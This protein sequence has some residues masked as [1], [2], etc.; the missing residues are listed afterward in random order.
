MLNCT[1]C[2]YGSPEGAK[3]CRQCGAPLFEGDFK[4]A[5]TR[6][7]GRQG[8]AVAPAA[9]A[10]LPPSIADAVAGDTARYQ[11]AVHMP[12]PSASIYTPPVGVAPAA[13]DTSSLKPKRRRILKWG[14]FVMAML[15]SAGI[16]AAINEEENSGRVYLSQEDRVRL[17]RLRT[18][19]RLQETLVGSV[20]EFQERRREEMERQ[21]EDIERAKEEAERAAER[22]ELGRSGEKPLDLTEFEYKGASAGEFSRIPGRELLTQRTSDNFDTVARY[23]QEKLGQPILQ[24][25]RRNRRQVVFQ[26]TGTPSVTVLVRESRERSRQPE[27]IIMRSPF[28]F[29]VSA[30]EAEAAKPA[31]AAEAKA[32][33]ELTQK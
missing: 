3:Y 29:P 4:E 28:R 2:G 21:L 14:G 12:Q 15:L 5:A 23:F 9:S 32:P 10:P 17:E 30:P 33:A 31:A 7:Y 6:N 20:T 24:L 22:G 25:N 11:Q 13:R 18:E 19:D 1:S 16:G 26:S 27:I 8:P